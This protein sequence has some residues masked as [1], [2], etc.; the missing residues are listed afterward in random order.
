VDGEVLTW[1]A[2]GLSFKAAPKGPWNQALHPRDA[3]GK[4]IQNGDPVLLS[5]T[6]GGG[7]GQVIGAR[8]SLISVRLAGGRVVHV[9]RSHLRVAAGVAAGAGGP[10]RRIIGVPTA[11]Q[12]ARSAP[13]GAPAR[14]QRPPMLTFTAEEQAIDELVA[15]GATFRNAYAEVFKLD[16]KVL[17]QLERASLV[18]VDRI[19]KK[20]LDPARRGLADEY[21]Y[22]NWLLKAGEPL[23]AD[24]RK[25][26][27]PAAAALRAAAQ[28]GFEAARSGEP[29]SVCPYPVTGEATGRL[30]AVAFVRGYARVLRPSAQTLRRRPAGG[31]ARH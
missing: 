28:A 22:L 30:L 27:R 19:A 23:P 8:G 10:A 11:V 4:F 15:G 7:R 17:L 29:I 25:A 3:G 21:V 20:I 24:E 12:A 26:A 18:D 6:V 13:P 16:P 1:S 14:P 9:G 2:G 5:A 31:A